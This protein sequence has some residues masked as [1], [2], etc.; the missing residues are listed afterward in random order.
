M[1]TTHN[2]PEIFKAQLDEVEPM[3][4]AAIDKM[5]ES[6]SKHFSAEKMI[7]LTEELNS[8]LGSKMFFYMVESKQEYTNQMSIQMLRAWECDYEAMQVELADYVQ[9]EVPEGVSTPKFVH[10]SLVKA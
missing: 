7:A 5:I 9:V 1:T 10:K 3:D 8:K 2:F 4:Q 6:R